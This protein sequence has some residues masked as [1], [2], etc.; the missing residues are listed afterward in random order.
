MSHGRTLVFAPIFERVCFSTARLQ[1][2]G[3]QQITSITVIFVR[4]SPTFLYVL[5]ALTA[6]VGHASAEVRLALYHIDLVFR[7]TWHP[8]VMDQVPS[9]KPRYIINPR[10]N[11]SSI[12][13]TGSDVMAPTFDFTYIASPS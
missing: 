12:S 9:I 10:Y 13:A 8:L 3:S 2:H 5:L 11:A 4:S 7:M 6:F 1:H